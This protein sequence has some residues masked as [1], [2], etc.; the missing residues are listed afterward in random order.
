MAWGYVGILGLGVAYVS[1]TP[2]GKTD[3][4]AGVSAWGGRFIIG[5][6]DATTPQLI[7]RSPGIHIIPYCRFKGPA[8]PDLLWC[9]DHSRYKR[10][11]LHR[12]PIGSALSGSPRLPFTIAP[13][14]WL[15]RRRRRHEA[16]G[17]P[18]EGSEPVTQQSETQNVQQTGFS[19]LSS[20][21]PLT[22]R[23]ASPLESKSATT[24]CPANPQPRCRATP[25]I[26]SL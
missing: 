7:P 23:N 25:S 1:V 17:F 15:R 19:L 10:S 2:S 6:Q 16:R 20:R 9:F 3:R 11:G 14:T 18:V 13:I 12:A 22:I 5:W 21:S 8:T 4:N 26:S 24:A